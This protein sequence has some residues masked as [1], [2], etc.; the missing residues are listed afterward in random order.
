MRANVEDFLGMLKALPERVMSY[1]C[2][3]DVRYATP[4]SCD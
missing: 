4:Y 1:F 2:H 3:P